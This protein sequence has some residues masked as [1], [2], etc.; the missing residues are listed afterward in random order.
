[1]ALRRR[2]RFRIRTWQDLL[3]LVLTCAVYFFCSYFLPK[4]FPDMSRK[5]IDV[6]SYALTLA[7]LVFVLIH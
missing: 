7:V 5:T 1:M 4:L 6:M 2:K 3:L